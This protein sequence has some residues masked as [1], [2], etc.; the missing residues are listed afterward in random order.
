MI[1]L[2]NVPGFK[3]FTPLINWNGPCWCSWWFFMFLNCK[4]WITLRQR[5]RSEQLEWSALFCGLRVNCIFSVWRTLFCLFCWLHL[6]NAWWAGPRHEPSL[7]SVHWRLPVSVDD[8]FIRMAARLKFYPNGHTAKIYKSAARLGDRFW[9]ISWLEHQP[10]D[11]FWQ[12]YFDLL[13]CAQRFTVGR[14]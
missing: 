11:W 12:N 5:W 10:S 2:W 1:W 8:S 6:D 14:W 7:S 13:H 4:P 3:T 9:R